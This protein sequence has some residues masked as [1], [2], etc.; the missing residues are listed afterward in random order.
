MIYALCFI[1]DVFLFISYA[2]CFMFDMLRF[3]PAIS[4][5]LKYLGIR[6]ILEL[7]VTCNLESK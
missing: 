1:V 4:P 2:L 7:E 6:Y 5:K 3:Q